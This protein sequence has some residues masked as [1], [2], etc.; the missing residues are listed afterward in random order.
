MRTARE[1]PLG[2]SSEIPD[3][4]LRGACVACGGD[5]SVRLRPEASRSVCRGCGCFA[6]VLVEYERDRLQL[7]PRSAGD[8]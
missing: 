3:L 2:P 1:D 4:E 7:E 5:L 6:W 8:A